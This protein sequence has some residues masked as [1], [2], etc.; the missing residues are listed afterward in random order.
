LNIRLWILS[1]ILIVFSSGNCKSGDFL[2]DTNGLV[3]FAPYFHGVNKT[4]GLHPSYRAEFH[5]NFDVFRF[6]KIIVSLKGGNTTLISSSDSSLINL[7]KIHYLLSPDVK[8]DF[9][10]WMLNLSFNHESIYSI[11]R[12]EQLNGANWQNSLRL[13]IGSKGSYNL[14]LYDVYRQHKDE[15]INKWDAQLNVGAFLYGNETIWRARNHDYRW[16]FFSLIRY[17][18]GTKGKWVLFT[19]AKSHWWLDVNQNIEYR[20][21]I[22]LNA[23]YLTKVKGFGLFYRFVPHDSYSS[24]N[25]NGLGSIGFKVL[26]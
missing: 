20:L 8:M 13:G 6:D 22:D 18:I 1:C 5:V 3:S 21:F 15:F 26:F 25:V 7:D 14:Y 10:S 12:S 16:E 2:F 24:D 19:G 17:H 23:L 9:G 11:S 4:A